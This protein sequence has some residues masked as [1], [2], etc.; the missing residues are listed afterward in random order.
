MKSQ[1]G[2]TMISLIMYVGSFL[3]ITVIVATITTFFYNNIEVLDTSIGSNSQY[4][5]FNLYF[6][7]EVKKG[8]NELFAWRESA[9]YQNVSRLT[10][11]TAIDKKFITFNNTI[12]G[13]KN[14]FIYDENNDDLYYNSIKLCDDVEDFQIKV[15][16][17][18]GKTVL[19]IFIKID[20]TA[21]STE[22]VIKG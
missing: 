11:A 10:D 9:T 15:D 8:N 18:T 17:S 4:N 12:D 2:M 22:Y 1:K 19:K 16:E 14:S 20:G 5:K 13:S 21:F 7:N 3:L 6:L